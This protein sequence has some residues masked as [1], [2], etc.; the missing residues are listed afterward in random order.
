[1]SGLPAGQFDGLGRVL[2]AVGA[3][4]VQDQDAVV[5]AWSSLP[6]SRP[7]PG[8]PPGGRQRAP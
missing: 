4:G 1:M 2:V 6:A 8:H 5:S 7:E 3:G